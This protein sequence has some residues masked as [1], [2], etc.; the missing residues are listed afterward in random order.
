MQRHTA[1]LN[2]TDDVTPV[3]GGG[4]GRKLKSSGGALDESQSLSHSMLLIIIS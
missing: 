2:C 1:A 3:A 4:H